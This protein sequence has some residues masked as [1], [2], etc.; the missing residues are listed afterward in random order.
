MT[1]TYMINRN[2]QDGDFHPS[3][4]LSNPFERSVDTNETIEPKQEYIENKA[5]LINALCNVL[6]SPIKAA[7]RDI[8][9]DKLQKLLESL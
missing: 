7:L 2:H 1:E 5:E 8:A 3:L 4:F 9:K 6:D